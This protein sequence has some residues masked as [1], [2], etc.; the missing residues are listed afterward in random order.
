MDQSYTS[1]ALPSHAAPTMRRRFAMPDT[2]VLGAMLTP[3]MVITLVF[4]FGFLL[5]TILVSFTNSTLLP[6]YGLVGWANYAKV[7]SSVRW[8]LSVTNLFLFGPLYIAACM[9]LG[10]FLA[11]LIDQRIRGENVL[12]SI[13]LYPMAVS[14]IVTGTVWQWLLNPATGIQAMVRGLGFQHFRFD[15]VADQRMAI[16][17]AVIAGAWHTS[18]F[19]MALFL[20]GLRS[21]DRELIHAAQIDGAGAIRIYRRITLPSIRPIFVA[22]FF[23]LAQDALKTY[24]LVVALTDGGPGLSSDLP[25][26]FV[27]DLIF[28]RGQIGQG[29]VG[30]TFMFLFVIILLVL[31][32]LLR[33][34]QRR[35]PTASQ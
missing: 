2:L 33:A 6:S 11:I 35:V 14:F 20:A 15:W 4:T 34:Y 24:D 8:S 23:I 16:Y 1:A 3:A 12:R 28:G 27:R 21:V 25:A 31:A 7:L 9:A 22:V 29:T 10:M 19:A 13:Y 30:A 32:Q 18:G 26:L 5:W 17:T